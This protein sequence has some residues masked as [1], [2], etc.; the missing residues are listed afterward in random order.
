MDRLT[1]HSYSKAELAQMYFP[2]STPATAVKRLMA[3]TRKCAPLLESLRLTGY[4]PICKMLTPRQ[5]E[6]IV[7]YLGDP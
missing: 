5:V 3:W 6:T 4:T 7:H 1:K 2:D